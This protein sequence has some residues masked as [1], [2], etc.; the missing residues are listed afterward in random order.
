MADG[1]YELAASVLDWAQ[2]RYQNSARLESMQR[3]AYLKLMEKYQEFNP[4]KFIVYSGKGG[5]DVPPLAPV[6]A[7][8]AGG[9]AK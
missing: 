7:A 4:F 9:Q 1:Q 2:G 3:T 5:L 6:T 8:P